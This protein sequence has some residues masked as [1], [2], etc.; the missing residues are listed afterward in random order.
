MTP[1]ARSLLVTS[2]L[3]LTSALGF[4]Q[5]PAALAP[6]A[7]PPPPAPAP[8]V[9][10]TVMVV[11]LRGETIPA[12]GYESWKD[13]LT[14]SANG[15]GV[16]GG[17]GAQG[18]GGFC[19]PALSP[20]L[21]L[22]GMQF[23]EV[24][25]GVGQGNEMPEVTIA[26]ADA[27]GTQVAARIRINQIVPLQPVWFRIPVVDLQPGTGQSAG[28]ILGMDWSK[29]TL[30]HLQGDWVTKKPANIVFIAIRARR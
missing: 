21:D 27:D 28:K 1:S 10:P 15:V 3:V 17:K 30:W 19:G 11:D 13:R 2:I 14:R 6:A 16:I 22:S 25:L 9:S 12:Y 29:V 24:A 8:A 18:D 20:A 7:P 23:I 26:L 4:A 5:E